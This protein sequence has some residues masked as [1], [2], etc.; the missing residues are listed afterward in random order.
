[1]RK[2]ICICLCTAAISARTAAL[3]P[4]LLPD[5]FGSWQA[6]GPAKTLRANELGSNWS[7][8]PNAQAVLKESGLSRIEER[9]YRNGNDEAAIRVFVL[10]NPTSAYEFYTFRLVPGMQ[11]LQLGDGAAAGERGVCV[12]VGN[13]VVEAALPGTAKPETL[14][15][16][17]KALKAKADPTPFPPLRGY[18]P[19]HWLVFG[20]Q[21][22]ALGPEAFRDAMLSLEQGANRDLATEIGFQD[23]AETMLARYQGEKGGAVLLLILYPTPQV[24]ENR[25]HHLEQAI[26]ASAK[27]AGVT[28][29]RKA[30]LLS[31]V[32]G[33]T[34]PMHAQAIRDEVNY[35]TEVTWNEPSTTA[36][37]PPL[38]LV[39]FKIFL[40]TSLFLVVATVAGIFFGGVRILI[41]HWLPGKVF[42]RPQN[43]EVIQLGLTGKKI[44][45]TDMY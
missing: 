1:M 35:E 29:E 28:V 14:A 31:I 30:S 34:I 45:P 40:F 26:P 8:W 13:L 15:D 27:A 41:K 4:S 33:T 18:L 42:D 36:T 3:E 24:A 10:D 19:T 25:L 44:D 22:Y 21:K 32:F 9:A 6:E 7:Q 20:S 43:I 17:V 2:L 38:V 37:D 11:S 23:E 16:L 39:L 12:L 5:G